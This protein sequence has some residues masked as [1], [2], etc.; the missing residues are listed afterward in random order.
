MLSAQCGPKGEWLSDT[1]MIHRAMIHD[2]LNEELTLY[3]QWR[4]TINN[5]C[6]DCVLLND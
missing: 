3:G 1:R 2:G 6:T 5:T 4:T